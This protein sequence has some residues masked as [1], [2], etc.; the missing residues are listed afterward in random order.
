MDREAVA[1]MVEVG[2]DMCRYKK[3]GNKV[4]VESIPTS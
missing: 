2:M 4:D 1:A 3:M